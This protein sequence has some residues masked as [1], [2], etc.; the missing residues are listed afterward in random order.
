MTRYDVT[1]IGSGIHGAGVAQAA[2][3]R[4]YRVLL[5]EKTAVAA[6]T[7]SRSSKLV[8]G[9]L[10]YLETAQF[11]LV[12]ECLR[13]RAILLKNAPELVTLRRFYIP[14]YTE[15]SRSPLLIRMG[16]SL[17]AVIGGFA[18][19][20][21]FH[22]VPKSR[23]HELDGLKT[24]GLRQVFCYYDAQT[25]DAALTQAVLNSAV[26]MGAQIKLPATFVAA[27]RKQSHSI[28]RYNHND[29]DIEIQTTVLI[30]AAGPWINHV[31]TSIRPILPP[32]A[33]SLVQGTHV[34]IDCKLQQGI[35]Y[36]ES[37]S[38]RRAVFAIPWKGRLLLGTTETHFT[39]EPESVEPSQPDQDYL[40]DIFAHYFPEIGKQGTQIV[41]SFA[42][43]RVLPAS[44]ESVFKRSRE[45]QLVVDDERCPK[46]LTIFGGKLTT[47]RAT[48]ENVMQRLQGQLPEVK[49]YRDTAKISLN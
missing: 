19:S 43:L 14:V 15:T 48:A 22:T 20:S 44:T 30:N 49:K 16:L 12:R 3:A 32:L 7:S 11:S 28:I 8:H 23:W 13:E 17:Y 4:G 40:L 5:L 45:T 9:G 41:E 18:K 10:R 33:L 34:V 26:S 25:D 6:G 42:G 46:I 29:K 27:L 47:Y 37:P 24:E 21:V 2:A 36:L 31:L 38:D 39:G 35:Y 1:I